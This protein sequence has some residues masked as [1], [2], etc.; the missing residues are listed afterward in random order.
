MERAKIPLK[1]IFAK[2]ML[3]AGKLTTVL[4][5]IEAQLNSCPLTYLGAD[6]EFNLPDFNLNLFENGDEKHLTFTEENDSSQEI[7]NFIA[8]QNAQNTVKKTSLTNRDLKRSG[9]LFTD[10][11]L[12]FTSIFKRAPS[13]TLKT[14]RLRTRTFQTQT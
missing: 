1:K 14:L 10:K 7:D 8:G 13:I 6:P 12:T 11:M 3:D 4:A 5:E 2:A 9:A